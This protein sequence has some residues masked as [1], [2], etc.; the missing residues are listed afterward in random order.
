MEVLQLNAPFVSTC[1]NHAPYRAAAYLHCSH[2]RARNIFLA[3]KH[4]IRPYRSTASTHYSHRLIA[5]PVVDTSV[6]QDLARGGV[7][8]AQRRLGIDPAKEAKWLK[9]KADRGIR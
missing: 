8:A 7:K 1:S 6:V 5:S 2:I 4:S 9:Y 3:K